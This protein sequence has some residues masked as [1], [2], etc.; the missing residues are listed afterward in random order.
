MDM[1]HHIFGRLADSAAFESLHPLFPKAFAFLRR[2]DI[3]SLAPGRY[4]IDGDRCW[5]SVADLEL[6]PAAEKMKYEVHRRYIDIQAP[7]TGPETFGV[8]E[9]SGGPEFDDER[10][11]GFFEAGGR[12]VTVAP[13]EFAVFMPGDGAHA[14]GHSD[15]G[16]RTVRKVVV[17]VLARQEAE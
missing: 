6:S 13:G 9:S 1:K 3:A 10:D 11:I 12:C 2:P 17:K 14:P 7:L 8:L 4:G 15:D 5:A 16:P